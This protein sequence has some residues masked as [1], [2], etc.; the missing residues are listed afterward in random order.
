MATYNVIKWKLLSCVQ[1]FAT[2]G[3]YNPWNSPGWNTGV[4]SRSLLQGNLPNPGI[5]P[6]SPIYRWILYQLSHQWSSIILEWVT[7]HFSSRYSRP[8]NWAGDPLFQV[9]SLPGE[10]LGKPIVIKWIKKCGI[11][12]IT[13]QMGETGRSSI[14]CKKIACAF[15]VVSS[16]LQPHGL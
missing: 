12:R 16:S 5:E 8:R 9:D 11:E 1:L 13:P 14:W 15:S 3:L 6:R 10:L 2:H 4:G 7:Y